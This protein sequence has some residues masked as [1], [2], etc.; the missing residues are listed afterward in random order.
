MRVPA[1]GADAADYYK[2]IRY[3]LTPPGQPI[4]E[5]DMMVAAH[6][7]ATGAVLV[8]NNTSHFERIDAPLALTN[9]LHGDL[10]RTYLPVAT[11]AE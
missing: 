1:W 11:G 6:A 7:L 4:G 9:W 2:D 5:M 3:Q 8:T 10:T